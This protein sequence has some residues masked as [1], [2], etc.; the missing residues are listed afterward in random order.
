MF[1]LDTSVLV[2]AITK[3]S[4]SP[5]VRDWLAAREPGELATSAWVATEFHSALGIKVRSGGLSAA[6]ARSA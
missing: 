4:G 1:Y 3:E 2:A 6:H 5:S